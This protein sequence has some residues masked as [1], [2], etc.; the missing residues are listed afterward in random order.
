MT[1]DASCSLYVSMKNGESEASYKYWGLFINSPT[2]HQ[3]LVLHVEGFSKNFRF[4]R[5]LADPRDSDN[6]S[7]LI[8]LCNVP[9]SHITLIDQPAEE[10]EV[11][12]E[13]AGYNCQ[14]YVLQLSDDLEARKLI[15]GKDAQYKKQKALVASKQEG[16]D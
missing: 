6:F 15:N 7:E 11:H 1:S 3:Q 13:F 14:D 16:F 4:D 2:T 5:Q 10:A 9:V 8:H 12:N